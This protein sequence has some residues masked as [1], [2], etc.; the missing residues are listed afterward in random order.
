M[1]RIPVIDLTSSRE[2]DLRARQAVARE[3]DRACREIGF[4]TI[5]G[6]GVPVAVMESLR[7][8]AHAF[9]ALP[10]DQKRKAIHPVAG[11]PR[12]YRALGIEALAHGNADATPPDLKEFYHFGKERWPAGP[13]YAGEEGR[14][15]FIPNLWP[16]EPA[17]F[18]EAASRCYEAM[19]NVAALM[20]RL[21]A[22][23]L[24]VDEHFFDDKIDRHITA[25]RLNFYPEQT[26]SPQP[27]QLRAGAHT[28]FGV[29]T[30][31]NGENVPGGLQVQAKGDGWIDVE[32]DPSTFVVNIGDLLMRWTNDRWVSNLHRVVNPPASVAARA[33]RLSIA[34][35]QQPNYDAPIECIAP[36]GK[37]KYPPVLS[38]AYRDMKYRQTAVAV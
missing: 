28:D 11:T 26:V 7:E 14:R 16:A 5:T 15:Y 35:F 29:F 36:P 34:F 9:F 4:F 31:L 27:G 19:E 1:E 12:G 18:G 2:G 33:K 21:A 37:A 8:K 6:H 17:G 25:M 38:G 23:A 20:M 32:T 30:I 22:L 13:Y 24:N 3:I 10:L